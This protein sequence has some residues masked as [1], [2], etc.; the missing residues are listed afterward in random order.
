MTCDQIQK[1]YMFDKDEI[2]IQARIKFLQ[3][4]D[5]RKENNLEKKHKQSIDNF[6]KDHNEEINNFSDQYENTGNKN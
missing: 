4:K 6:A 3:E 1:K 2:H 5:N